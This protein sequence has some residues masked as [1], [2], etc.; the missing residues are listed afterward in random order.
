MNII[1]KFW[2]LGTKMNQIV[3]DS[4]RQ[5]VQIVDVDFKFKQLINLSIFFN[6][7]YYVVFLS[8][9][10]TNC[11]NII[12]KF[13]N[14]GTKM[15]QIVD[16]S[17][18]QTVQIVDVDFKFKQLNNLS[19]FFDSVYYFAS[20]SLLCTNLCRILPWSRGLRWL[21]WDQST[22]RSNSKCLKCRFNGDDRKQQ[23]QIASCCVEFLIWVTTNCQC[24]ISPSVPSPA[25]KNNKQPATWIVKVMNLQ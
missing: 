18:R 25:T 21:K 16:D 2:N 20:I 24:H 11:V 6:S 9:L 10:A 13:W 8:L 19:I 3:T 1:V 4:S 5:T 22:T 17:S 15:N 7:V 23:F 14:L 12:V